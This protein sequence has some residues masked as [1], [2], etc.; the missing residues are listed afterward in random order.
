M[1]K[2]TTA[3]IIAAGEASRWGDY[4]GIPKHLID[5]HGQPLLTR[6]VNQLSTKVPHVWVVARNDDRYRNHQ[7]RTLTV[8]PSDSDMDKFYSGRRL[9]GNQHILIVYGDV[10]FTD[11]AIATITQPVTDWHLYC[12]PHGST[13]TGSQHGECWAFSIPPKDHQQVLAAIIHLAG[14]HHLGQAPRTGGW[15]LYRHLCGTPLDSHTM[16]PGTYTIID[17]HTEDFDY[18]SDY[19]LWAYTTKILDREY[20][21]IDPFDD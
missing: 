9:W 4:K 8:E 18:P 12:R 11:T 3:I 10:Y 6:T 19:E 15:E 1:T 13:K 5:I 16:K 7:G 14:L 21:P 20:T 17:D 2:P